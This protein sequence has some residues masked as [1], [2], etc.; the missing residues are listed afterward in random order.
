MGGQLDQ[1]VYSK[2]TRPDQVLSPLRRWGLGMRQFPAHLT[3]C[4]AIC[5]STVDHK[6]Q[7]GCLEAFHLLSH[8]YPPPAMPA[9]W[10]CLEKP[11]S[12]LTV[13]LQLLTSSRIVWGIQGEL[14]VKFHYSEFYHITVKF[15]GCEY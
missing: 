1:V 3:T 14:H 5:S 13:L 9:V 4:D 12:I 7:R 11:Y 8:H 2:V 6:L 15:G 10:G